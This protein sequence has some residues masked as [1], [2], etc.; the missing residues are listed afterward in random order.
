MLCLW[1]AA[2]SRLTTTWVNAA[3]CFR[4]EAVRA[5]RLADAA[6][7][8]PTGAVPAYDARRVYAKRF[9]SQVL[10]GTCSAE[11]FYEYL[12]ISRGYPHPTKRV[13]GGAAAAA[14]ATDAVDAVN[15]VDAVDA[16]DADDADAA[17][18]ATD[19]DDGDAH[20]VDESSDDAES[21]EGSVSEA[22][23]VEQGGAAGAAERDEDDVSGD[24]ADAAL[25][26]AGSSVPIDVDAPTRCEGNVA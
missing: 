21:D 20:I 13:K 15:A 5:Q 22:A 9:V 25:S 16:D 6:A 23:S 1:A 12:T 17:D 10:D 14:E 19:D 2:T 18:T 3:A 8:I 7:L 4:R 26:A 11:E 24:D